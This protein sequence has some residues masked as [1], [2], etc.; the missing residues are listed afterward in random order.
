MKRKLR[1]L[2]FLVLAGLLVFSSTGVNA[3]GGKPVKELTL[4]QSIDLAL[5]QNSKMELNQIVVDKAYA[6]LEGAEAS[7]DRLSVE[8]VQTYEAGYLKWVAPALAK[9]GVIMGV[10]QQKLGF[11][12]LKLEVE[13][14]YYD[15]LK[16]ERYLAIKK[17]SLQR[18]QEQ[19]KIAQA[20]LKAGTIAKGDLVAVEAGVARSQADVVS[21]QNDYNITLMKFNKVLGLNLDTPVKLNTKFI[22]EPSKAIDYAES[23][24]DALANNIEILKVKE[25]LEVKQEEFRVANKFYGGGVAIFEKAKF[26]QREAEIKVKQQEIDTTLAVKEAWLNLRSAE[27]ML[28]FL[29]KN[30]EKEKENVRIVTLKYKNGLATH[31]DMSGADLALEEAEKLYADTLYGYNTAKAAFKYGIFQS[32]GGSIGAAGAMGKR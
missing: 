11:K 8:Y 25:D 29:V 17:A 24:K 23:L 26:T 32:A 12:A 15:V 30:V 21:A 16:A 5:K 18:A 19:Y 4:H 6:E 10:E 28:G 2:S 9:F 7:A 3:A 14:A 1:L 27:E 13:S 31:L 22:Y 20:N